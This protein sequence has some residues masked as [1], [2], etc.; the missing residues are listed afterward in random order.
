MA[1]IFSMV[2]VAP[3]PFLMLVISLG[4]FVLLLMNTLQMLIPAAVEFFEYY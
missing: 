2:S 1:V 3:S 4:V